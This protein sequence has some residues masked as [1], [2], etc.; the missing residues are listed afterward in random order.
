MEGSIAKANLRKRG[1]LRQTG[2]APEAASRMPGYRPEVSAMTPIEERAP[3]DRTASTGSVTL[4]LV[5]AAVLVGLAIFLLVVGPER[6]EP[7]ILAILAALGVVGVFA[8]FAW[9]AGI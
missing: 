2:Q 3:V 7:F 8:L 1:V 6:A 5:V 4:V 9:A